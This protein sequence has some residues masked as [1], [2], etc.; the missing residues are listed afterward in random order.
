MICVWDNILVYHMK[1]LGSSSK[2]PKIAACLDWVNQQDWQQCQVPDCVQVFSLTRVWDLASPTSA[3]SFNCS[4]DKSSCSSSSG[5]G[6]DALNIHVHLDQSQAICWIRGL[7]NML[8]FKFAEQFYIIKGTVWLYWFLQ[9]SHH[10]WTNLP[11]ISCNMRI[12]RSQRWHR[13]ESVCIS[14]LTVYLSVYADT[15]WQDPWLT[16]CSNVTPILW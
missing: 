12:T 3:L 8:V 16:P 13:C 6:R 14:D 15:P 1:S 5:G 9:C 7:H 11:H 4:T 10:R 2:Q